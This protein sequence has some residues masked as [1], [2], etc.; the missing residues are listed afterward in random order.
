VR[1]RPMP[2]LSAL[3]LFVP[4]LGCA[5]GKPPELIPQVVERRVI[6]PQELL[7]CADEPPVPAM[8]LD[9]EETDYLA[10]ALDAGA[11]CREKLAQVRDFVAGK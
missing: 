6:P 5:S 11:D 8:T 3:L 2:G 7:S 10:S 1:L 4:L 9:T